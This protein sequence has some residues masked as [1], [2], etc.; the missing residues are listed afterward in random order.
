YVISETHAAGPDLARLVELVAPSAA[1]RL[2]DV[3]TGGGHVALA[4]APHAGLTVASDLTLAMLVEARR[5]M[6]D[7][8]FPVVVCCAADAEHL[9]FGE[10]SFTAVTCRI[11]LHHVP[12]IERAL[13]EVYR[14]LAPGGCFGFVDSMVPDD[15][16]L[17]EFLN[18]VERLR[19]PTHVRSRTRSEWIALLEAAGF[20]IEAAEVFKKTHAFASWAGRSSQL[21]AAGRQALEEEFL[22]APSEVAEYFRYEVADGRLVSYTDDKLLLLGRKG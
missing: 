3:A 8:G 22:S 20:H 7:R 6:T 9:P 17:A 11:A 4:L 19:D 1:G 2:L 5:F 10:A 12:A 21:D 16:K 15:L 14:V 13:G 18:H